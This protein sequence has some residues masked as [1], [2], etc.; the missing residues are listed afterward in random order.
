MARVAY[1]VELPL[2]QITNLI[3][4][5]RNGTLQDEAKDFAIDAWNVTG[6]ILNVTVGSPLPIING[7]PPVATDEFR[8]ACNELL[9]LL[10]PPAVAGQPVG[11]DLSV[12]LKNIGLIGFVAAF[13]QFVLDVLNI[14]S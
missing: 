12:F 5:I 4:I 13:K 14:K 9:G 1:P 10:D 6:Y 7:P 11:S 3:R 8:L 2:G